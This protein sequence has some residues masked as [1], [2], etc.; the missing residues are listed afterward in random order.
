MPDPAEARLIGTG[1]D[2]II[3]AACE[4][5]ICPT[6]KGKCPF[7]DNPPKRENVESILIRADGQKVPI[8]KTVIPVVI[9]G[10]PAFLESILDITDRKRAEDAIQ[11]AYFD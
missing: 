5:F 4:N 1:R 8:L 6:V 11:K 7:T 3:G 10:K 2:A 9:S